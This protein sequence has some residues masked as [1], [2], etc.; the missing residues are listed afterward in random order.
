LVESPVLS[1][2]ALTEDQAEWWSRNRN[3]EREWFTDRLGLQLE[4]RAEGA[5]AVDPDDELTDVS[6]P[7]TG[8]TRHLALLWLERLVDLARDDAR[9]ADLADRTW[10]AIDG[11]VAEREGDAVLAQW[12]S[13]L[14]REHREDHARAKADATAVLVDAGLVR[15]DATGT[16]WLHAAAARYAA[17]PTLTSAAPS[18][19]ASLFD[20]EDMP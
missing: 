1:T 12:G 5:L 6:F 18:G 2:A 20:D 13:G 17:R 16:W 19:E 7:G 3:R 14:K 4:L 15:T 11:G 8:S 9:R 10:R